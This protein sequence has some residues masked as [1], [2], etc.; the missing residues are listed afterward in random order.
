MRWRKRRIKREKKTIEA[1]IAL[2]CRDHHQAEP[3]PCETCADL[4]AYARQRL[5]RCPWGESKPTCAKCPIHCYQPEMREQVR[6]VMRYAGPRMLLHHP[7][8]A[9]AHLLDGLG[10][11]KGSASKAPGE[12]R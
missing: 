9:I 5:E 8:L 7:I 3:T 12:K 1:M 6:R 11:A 10:S 2:Y 4:L